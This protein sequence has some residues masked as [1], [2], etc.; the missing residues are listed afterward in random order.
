MSYSSSGGSGFASA[1]SSYDLDSSTSLQESVTMGGGISKTMTSAG[2]GRNRMEQ[3]I[4]GSGETGSFSAESRVESVGAMSIGSSSLSS[5][6]SGALSQSVSCLGDAQVQVQA[7]QGSSE[8]L[9]R[10]VVSAG[11]LS[12]SQS[13]AAADEITSGQAVAGMGN[14]VGA[15]SEGQTGSAG[16]VQ[17]ASVLYGSMSAELGTTTAGCG[18]SSSQSTLIEGA[19][20]SISSSSMSDSTHM[21][22]AGDFLGTGSIE[23]DL[24][25]GSDAA[26][27]GSISVD[28]AEWMSGSDMER[29]H[30]EGGG[31]AV[32]GLRALDDGVGTFGVAAESGSLGEN[33]ATLMQGGSDSSYALIGW[34]WNTRDPR[35]QLYLKNDDQLAG[36]GLTAAQAQAAIAAAANTWDDA[37]GQNLF[38]DG[39]PVIISSSVNTDNPWD[40][41][42]VHA[43]KYLKDAPSALAYSR[44]RYGNPVVDGY[45]SVLESDVSYNTRYSWSTDGVNHIDVQTV[46]LHELGHTIGLGDLY[47][48]PESDPRRYDY[49]QVMNAYN[50]IQ[51]TLGNGDRAGAVQLY[52]API[53]VAAYGGLYRM[54]GYGD[55][56]YTTSYPE[57][58][59]ANSIG[60]RY[61]GIAGYIYP[62]NQDG[63]IPLYRMYGYGDHFYTTSYPE[64]QFANSIGYR[65]EGI[66][67]YIYPSNQDGTIPLYR[68][69]GYGD[70]FYTTNYPE[71][72][73]ANSIGYRYE[74]I[75]GYILPVG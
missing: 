57:V 55:H 11:Y 51:R 35:I 65:Y 62:S 25:T 9:E 30:Q 33:V 50:D 48:L 22:V 47:T 53:P 52:G 24:S 49:D 31:L 38:A 44:T 39:T 23:A 4:S 61:E 18:V 68:M 10:A 63:T 64:V 3:T 41:V 45:Y 17:M 21:T 5:G 26:V 27:R 71:V 20:G 32:H 72:Q 67:G 15:V 37:V 66:A 2:A 40:G 74:G 13:V 29:V 12:A 43:W 73:F 56:F 8:S 54:Y 70:H 69:Y 6:G 58:Q 46:A 28:G 7:Q 36:E 42:N 14:Y 34:R 19:A 16:S 59:F 1:S 60:Y 75:A